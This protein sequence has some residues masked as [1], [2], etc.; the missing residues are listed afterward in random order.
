M[1]AEQAETAALP[2]AR[3]RRRRRRRHQPDA[4]VGHGQDGPAPS[5]LEGD[6]HLGGGGVL[7]DVV[8]RLLHDAEGL[9]LDLVREPSGVH[10]DGAERGRDPER[11][12]PVG[13]RLTQH[14]QEPQLVEAGGT[15]IAQQEVDVL[16]DAFGGL[17]D[18]ADATGPAPRLRSTGRPAIPA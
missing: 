17:L 13:H 3:S 6:L 2:G 18:G 7:V 5:P 8:Q 12:R 10:A 14:R 1:H 9:R 15:Q 16:V 11:R 4:V